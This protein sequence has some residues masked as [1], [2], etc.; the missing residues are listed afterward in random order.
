MV[1][2]QACRRLSPDFLFA[3]NNRRC[4]YVMLDT[5]VRDVIS[6][7]HLHR[8]GCRAGKHHRLASR[9]LATNVNNQNVN[10][11]RSADQAIPTIISAWRRHRPVADAR[12]REPRSSVIKPVQRCTFHKSIR[13]GLFNARSVS[14]KSA[15]VQ[16]W[17]NDSHLNLVALVETWHD[18]AASPDLIASVPPGFKFVEKA[19]P[20]KTEQ[21]LTT[22]YCT[23]HHSTLVSCN[24][25][26]SRHSR[27]SARTFIELALTSSSLSS[28]DRAHRGSRRC[29]LLTSPI[30]L[31]G[32]LSTRRR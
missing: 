19:R 9:P 14:N 30:C 31:N 11:R 32:W 12:C 2:T 10:S 22:N 17:I 20:R 8:R 7:L 29:S 23:T 1:L 3:I 6:R 4:K 13:V 5:A 25:P 21:S 27:W 16:R 18:D 28:T 24:C 26:S 15:S